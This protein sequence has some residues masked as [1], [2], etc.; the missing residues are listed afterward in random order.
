[1]SKNVVNRYYGGVIAP[2]DPLCDNDWNRVSSQIY[3]FVLAEFIA[4]NWKFW[5]D[6][7]ERYIYRLLDG[8]LWDNASIS[9]RNLS[10][11][12]SKKKKKKRMSVIKHDR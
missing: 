6:A 12:P 7:K 4:F 5:Q 3:C 9:H 8:A 10:I 2:V 1:M 11:I